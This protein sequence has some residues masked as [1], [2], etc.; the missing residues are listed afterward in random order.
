ME[1]I[2]IFNTRANN[3]GR[4]LVRDLFEIIKTNPNLSQFS[5]EIISECK[6]RLT[7][8]VSLDEV[9]LCLVKRRNTRASTQVPS[10]PPENLSAT[11]NPSL[12][13]GVLKEMFDRFDINKDST[14]SLTELKKGLFDRFSPKS[15]EE[16]FSE[17]DF[18][19]NGCLDF[20]E[21]VRLFSPD[22]ACIPNL[23]NQPNC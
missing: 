14:I 17:Y 16:M 9:K 5:D 21:F 22:A 6:F 4:I 15:I 11:P 7:S 10:K 13:I 19:G 2:E 8:E 3:K 1:I 18:D 23:L 12:N 20:N